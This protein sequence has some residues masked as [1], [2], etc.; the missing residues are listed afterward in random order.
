MKNRKTG[1]LKNTVAKQVIFTL[2]QAD[3]NYNLNELSGDYIG[4]YAADNVLFLLTH[5]AIFAL[6]IKVILLI[7]VKRDK[8]IIQFMILLFKV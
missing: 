7:I 5:N 4:F 8:M 1:A 3:S 6:N 2:S